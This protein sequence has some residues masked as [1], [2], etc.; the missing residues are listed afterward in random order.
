VYQSTRCDLD[1]V[2]WN[3]YFIIKQPDWFLA[4]F[5]DFT[6]KSDLLFLIDF[7]VRQRL[8]DLDWFICKG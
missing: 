3:D 1:P 7:C 4:E 2:I 5:I 6:C 8:G